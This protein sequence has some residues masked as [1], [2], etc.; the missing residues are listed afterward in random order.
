MGQVIFTAEGVALPSMDDVGLALSMLDG[1]AT[2]SPSM[3]DGTIA[4]PT[5]VDQGVCV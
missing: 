1:E 2:S 5:M 4:L 3:I